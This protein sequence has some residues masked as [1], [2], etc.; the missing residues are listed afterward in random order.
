M[1][2]FFGAVVPRYDVD[3]RRVVDL[4]V[5]FEG[6]GFSSLWVTD[7]LQPSRASTVLESWTLLS[8]LAPATD[9]RLGTCVLCACYRHPAL[10]AKMA[11]TLDVLSSGRLEL[12]LGLGS[13]PQDAEL[14]A[15]G[16][17]RWAVEERVE[18]FREYVEV[19]RLLMTGKHT[20]DYGGRF[21]KLF[22]AVC[23]TPTL[24]KPS[25][26]IW[27][28]GRKKKIAGVAAELGVGWNF[29]GEALDE[30]ENVVKFYDEK[31]KQLGRK[32]VK[33]V[34]TNIVVYNSDSD[35]AEKMK[36]L[37]SYSSA[38]QALRRTFTLIHGKPDEV[39][40]QVEQLQN[41]GVG[42]IIVRDMD[43]EASSIKVFAKEVMPSFL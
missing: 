35:R 32:P 34:F 15:L 29:Y 5:L 4:A 11:A 42:L 31:C 7:H 19:V 30:C 38:E 39:V 16:M 27:V 26:P 41:L 21:Y 1:V 23:N 8:A 13:E 40:K 14:N 17:E 37:G 12:G 43:L 9:A 24:Q 3:V 20:V 22:K 36:K 25:P 28:G 33:S 2:L 6:L 10:L 18:R